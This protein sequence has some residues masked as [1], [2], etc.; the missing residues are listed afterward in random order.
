MITGSGAVEAVEAQIARLADSARAALA[1]TSELDPVAR[2]SLDALI[3]SATA[4]AS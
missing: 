4:R 3:E 2:E 1:A